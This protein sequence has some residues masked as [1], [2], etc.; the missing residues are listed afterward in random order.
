MINIQIPSTQALKV[1][2]AVARYSNC[3]RA[4][5]ELCLTTSA[6]SKQ[7]QTLE[8]SV[9]VELFTRG[10]RG[11]KLTEA[12]QIYLDCIKPILIKLAEAGMMATRQHLRSQVLQVQVPPVF[13]DRWL[14]PRYSRLAD[15]H[16]K[17]KIQFSTYPLVKPDDTFPYMYDAY[18]CIGEGEWPGCISDYICG[19]KLLLVASPNLLLNKPKINKPSDITNFNIL[20]HSEVPLVWAQAFDRLQINP[21]DVPRSIQWDFYSVLIRSACVGL[22]LALIPE[23]FITE[24][25]KSGDLV[26]VLDYSQTIS[27]AYYF[28]FSEEHQDDELISQFRNWLKPQTIAT[29]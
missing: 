9:G 4:A 7:L 22:G 5:Q 12:G 17:G 18:V 29:E 10:K 15:S 11:L 2:E 14:L 19:R 28:V 3:T 8:D 1:F 21:E 20:E 25:L 16:L 26:R 23:C 24:E 13:A 6:V 27:R